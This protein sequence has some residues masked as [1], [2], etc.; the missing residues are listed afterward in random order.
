MNSFRLSFSTTKKMNNQLIFTKNFVLSAKI[1]YPKEYKDL[2]PIDFNSHDAKKTDVRFRLFQKRGDKSGKILTEETVKTVNMYRDLPTKCFIHGWTS[3]E[4]TYWYNP[5]RD[6]Y[7]RKGSYNIFYIDWSGP[8][9][10]SF[11]ESAANSKPV[12]EFIADFFMASK[13]NVKNIHIIA[14]SLGAHVAGFA[15]KH[16]FGKIRRKLGRITATDPAGPLF[17][18]KEVTQNFRLCK[19]DAEFVDVVHTDI[20]HYGFIAPIGH[21]DF[22][23]N[24]GTKQPGCPPLTEDGE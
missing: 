20:G 5:L 3:N 18:R 7:F 17:E 22:Y 19:D 11:H 16:V 13:I 1:D 4:E 6:A 12:G 9:N 24:G 10:K 2:K 23:P 14:H 15:G 21:V 8:A